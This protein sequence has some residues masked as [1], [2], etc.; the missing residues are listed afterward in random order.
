[1]TS[2][3]AAAESPFLTGDPYDTRVERTFGFVD[4]SGFTRFSDER[5]DGEAVRLLALFRSAVREV[6]ARRGVRIAKWLGD[7]AM[8]VSVEREPLVEA[9]VAVQ[10]L[11]CECPL[12]LPLRAGVAA[13]PVILFEGD[14]YIGMAVNLASRLAELAGPGEVLAPADVVSSLMVNTK[15]EAIGLRSVPGLVEPIGLVRLSSVEA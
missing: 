7:G 3:P 12:P 5:G 15:A 1:M 2:V 4:L 14:D 6:A 11:L 10:D 13:G 8:L 9:I